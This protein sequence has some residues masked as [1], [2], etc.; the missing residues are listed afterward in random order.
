MKWRFKKDLSGNEEAKE[1][2]EIVNKLLARTDVERLISPKSDEYFL[3]DRVNQ[4][5]VVIGDDKILIANHTFSVPVELGLE[6]TESVKKIVRDKL[7]DERQALKG[8][9]FENKVDLLKRIKDSI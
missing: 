5:C 9:L 8:S 6:F 4:Y 2:L 3:I 1:T 7:E